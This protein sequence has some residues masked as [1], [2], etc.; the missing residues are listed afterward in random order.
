[1]TFKQSLGRIAA[2][3]QHGQ[4][5]DEGIGHVLPYEFLFEHAK[6]DDALHVG[7][8]S[9]LMFQVD[10]RIELGLRHFFQFCLHLLQQVVSLH[11][12][13]ADSLGGISRLQQTEQRTEGIG[14]AKIILHSHALCPPHNLREAG[15]EFIVHKFVFPVA[16][17][18]AALCCVWSQPLF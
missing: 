10:Q 2:V 16:R 4:H 13:S 11:A 17:T 15:R 6:F 1:M 12:Q 8:H 9:G 18:L 3:V 14:L 7:I 5:H